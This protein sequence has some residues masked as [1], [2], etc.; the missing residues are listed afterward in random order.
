VLV[1][2]VILVIVLIVVTP[3]F[4]PSGGGGATKFGLPAHLLPCALGLLFVTAA[5]ALLARLELPDP[6]FQVL[7][8]DVLRRVLVAFVA[9]VGGEVARRR[10]AGAT[11]LR[12]MPIE[13]EVGLVIERRGRPRC[14]LVAEIAARFHTRVDQI[15]GSLPFVTIVA[16]LQRGG[17]QQPVL[18]TLDGSI[19]VG[20]R[21][22]RMTTEAGVLAQAPVKGDPP[23]PEQEGAAHG[24]DADLLEK[25]AGDAAGAFHAAE[26]GVA[27]KTGFVCAG[28]SVEEM[29]GAQHRLAL[30][31]GKPAVEEEQSK[32]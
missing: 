1:V 13:A 10:V 6:F 8:P 25:M 3:L 4:T 12:M 30:P 17:Q 26:G 32:G 11:V 23:G 22:V 27:P 24:P 20:P 21:V 19:G 18:E 14:G 7:R 2:F 5:V 28:V 31:V 16:G 9:G 15:A 29:P